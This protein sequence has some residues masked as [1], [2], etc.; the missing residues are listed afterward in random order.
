MNTVQVG[1][2]VESVQKWNPRRDG[3]GTFTY[4]DLSS[5]DQVDKAVTQ[6]TTVAT[7]EAPSRARQLIAAGDVLVSTV[8]PNLNTVAYVGPNLDGATA[9]T[10]FCVLRPRP[11][12]L[13]GRYLFHWVQ[14]DQFI[15]Y[16]VQ[17]ATG[18]SYPAVSDKIVKAASIRLPPIEEQRRIAAVLDAARALRVKRHLALAKLDYL[19]QAIFIDMFGDPTRN[20]KRLDQVRLGDLIKLKSGEGLTARAMRPGPH[21]VYGGNGVSGSHDEYMFDEPKI[22]IGRV[23]VYCGCVHTAEPWSW[24]TDNAMYVHS[25]SPRLRHPYLAAALAQANLNQYASQAAQPLIS[26]SRV[27]PV[28][29]LVPPMDEQRSYEERIQAV[30]AL[31][32]VLDRGSRIHDHLFASLQQRAFRGEL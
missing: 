31:R 16:L 12:E 18:A 15:G 30:D 24:I 5:V 7:S 29:I 27:Y 19:T 22:V 28:E 9:S 21:L 17:L 2:L 25:S 8:R 20:P 4:V 23:G 10:G 3:G 1:H 11:D 32:R 14:T 13:D 6:S 26:G